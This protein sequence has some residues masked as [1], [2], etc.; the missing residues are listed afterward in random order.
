MHYPLFCEMFVSKWHYWTFKSFGMLCWVSSSWHFQYHSA[1]H[2]WNYQSN[3]TKSHL[4][5]LECWHKIYL[6]NNLPYSSRPYECSKKLLFKYIFNPLTHNKINAAYIEAQTHHTTQRLPAISKCVTIA[7]QTTQFPSQCCWS[8]RQMD[9]WQ[10][11]PAARLGMY[12]PVLRSKKKDSSN[13]NSSTS[14]MQWLL[15]I[16]FISQQVNALPIVLWD[17]CL[18]VALLNIQVLWDAML[19]QQFLTF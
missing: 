6:N 1:L 15:F 16:I 2:I 17:V 9:G 14:F 8:K 10:W 12:N 18:K 13:V 3:V 7:Q 5:I 19:G 4:R 11:T